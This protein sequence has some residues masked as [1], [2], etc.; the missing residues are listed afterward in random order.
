M[1]LESDDENDRVEHENESYL[2]DEDYVHE[3]LF[4]RF[5]YQD[6]FSENELNMNKEY[7][8]GKD[9]ESKWRKKPVRKQIRK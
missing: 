7:F 2:E 4:R 3:S 5:G 9:K 8:F 6:I 1:L